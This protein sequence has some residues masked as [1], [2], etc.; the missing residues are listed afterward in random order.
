M[1]AGGSPEPGKITVV[2]DDVQDVGQ[3]VYTIADT[4]RQA[5]DAAARE[6]ST[7]LESDWTGDAADEFRTGW[8]ETRDGGTQLMQAL[9]AL[10]EKLGVTAENYRKSD[11]DSATALG[12]LDMS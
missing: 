12:S 2:P 1:T 4:L 6:V 8:D 9:S 5:L 10:A 11:T 3:Y 7:L